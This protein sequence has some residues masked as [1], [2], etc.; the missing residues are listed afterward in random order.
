[1]SFAMMHEAVRIADRFHGA[2]DFETIEQQGRLQNVIVLVF[3]FHMLMVVGFIKLQEFDARSPAIVRDMD[4]SFLMAPPPPDPLYR[5]HTPAPPVPVN[6]PGSARPANAID[7][8]AGI[9]QHPLPPPPSIGP[10]RKS[11][12]LPVTAQPPRREVLESPV[13]LTPNNNVRVDP[14]QI[15]QEKLPTLPEQRIAVN[16]P[17]PAP[18]IAAQEPLDNL[19]GTGSKTSLPN[20]SRTTAGGGVGN[21]GLAPGAG[22]GAGVEVS[23]TVPAVAE[24][25]VAEYRQHLLLRIAHSW[26][27]KGSFKSL[28]VLLEINHQGRLVG[29]EIEQSSGKKKVD[30]YALEALDATDF[31]PLPDFYKP[32]TLKFRITLSASDVER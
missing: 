30:R 28:V 19:P 23:V 14:R 32:D 3:I 10:A 18:P 8:S 9:E 26:H 27:P 17:S 24:W 7:H 4:V 5:P 6:P 25:N 13:A 20:P 29:R 11:E 21:D 1:M 22:T 16:A 31:E 12:H 15:V 2:R